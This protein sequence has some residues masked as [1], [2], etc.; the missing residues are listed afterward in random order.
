MRGNGDVPNVANNVEAG[1][2]SNEAQKQPQPAASSGSG[3]KKKGTELIL[4]EV[5]KQTTAPTYADLYRAREATIGLYYSDIDEK[6]T[7]ALH[8]I[9]PITAHPD[10][11]LRKMGI[12]QQ[13]GEV[14]G[15]LNRLNRRRRKK[16]WPPWRD[17]PESTVK[18]D[19][20]QGSWVNMATF[21]PEWDC[22]EE[23]VKK[24][25][26]TVP[27]AIINVLGS[28]RLS[29]LK[30]EMSA[31]DQKR[32]EGRKFLDII[33][34]MEHEHG[35]EQTASPKSKTKCHVA[36]QPKMVPRADTGGLQKLIDSDSDD[37]MKR[38]VVDGVVQQRVVNSEKRKVTR[39]Q[40]LLARSIPTAAY[41]T[42]AVIICNGRDKEE[43]ARGP[44]S[45]IPK[46]LAKGVKAM[47]TWNFRQPSL[48][49]INEYRGRKGDKDRSL[50]PHF[51]AHLQL[52]VKPRQPKDS[53]DSPSKAGQEVKCP[54]CSNT[55]LKPADTKAHPICGDCKVLKYTQ[56]FV[57]ELAQGTSAR[58]ARHHTSQTLATS[59]SHRQ[60]KTQ[61]PPKR[62][63]VPLVSVVVGGDVEQTKTAMMHSVRNNWPI[64]VVAGSGGYADVLCGLID[65]VNAL[66]PNA[67][68][69]EFRQHLGAVDATTAE[70]I[71]EGRLTIIAEGQLS[72]EVKR[73]ICFA[74]KGD[75]TL[76]MAWY[77]YATWASN[78]LEQ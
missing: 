46:E 27:K 38:S 51:H 52:N 68:T 43:E 64:L 57:A 36:L 12:I 42:D 44:Y 21:A 73:T 78:G 61:E 54:R 1:L 16:F 58:M 15:C 3:V 6:R 32:A 7:K 50:N 66:A 8:F 11:V 65:R 53:A 33:N 34:H 35:M 72:D 49:C 26:D 77:K 17:W 75:E 70:I 45:D 69:D 37:E 22:R 55:V 5:F 18:Y 30:P 76:Y 23:D 9:E 20:Y 19:V 71:N 67:G 25:T 47:T 39:I 60:K 28:V 4:E 14:T 31:V 2:S 40:Q 10:S 13:T 41:V 62:S 56:E 59:R 74:L 63:P 29:D 48:I 24:R